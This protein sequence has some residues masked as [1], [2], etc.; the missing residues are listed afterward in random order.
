MAMGKAATTP[1]KHPRPGTISRFDRR[2]EEILN[3]AGLLFNLHGLRDATLAVIAADIGLNLKSLRYYFE[4]R[5]D[6]VAA[7]FMRSIELHQGLAQDALR[8]VGIEARVRRFVGSYFDLRASV[9]K[10]ER[11]EFVHFGDLRA[12]TAP[13]SEIVWPAYSQMFKSI[14]QLFR[15]PEVDWTA[16]DLNAR[17][18]LLL[19]QILWSVVW[20]SEY[21]PE[22]ASQ[23]AARFCDILLGGVAA[24]PVDVKKSTPV[25]SPVEEEEVDRVSQFAFLRTATALINQHGYRGA[26]VDRIS[27]ELKVSKGSFYH[28]NETRDGLVVACFEHSFGLLRQAQDAALARDVNGASRVIEASVSLVTRQ[29]VDNGTLLRTSA[30]TA[31][32]PDL[33]ARMA[34]EISRLTLRFGDMLNEGLIDGS[35]RPCNIRI[36]AE[37]VTAMINSAEELSRWVPAATADNAAEL[38]VRPLLNGLLPRR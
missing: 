11:P 10:G 33:R 29:M 22:D 7:A 12:L 14:R 34:R 21:F 27:A 16:S 19:S 13:H 30:L 18:H 31:L 6:L 9:A 24:Q 5:E 20:A 4:R 26:S 1:G 36:A 3:A 17:T 23:V 25:P 35:V 37:M 38:Y 32:G 28:H 15:T 8:E 2:K